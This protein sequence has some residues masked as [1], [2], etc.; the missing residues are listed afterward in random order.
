MFISWEKTQTVWQSP[1]PGLQWLEGLEYY[2]QGASLTAHSPDFSMRKSPGANGLWVHLGGENGPEGAGGKF[3]QSHPLFV[4]WFLELSLSFFFFLFKHR[5]HTRG[6]WQFSDVLVRIEGRSHWDSIFPSLCYE[7]K[8]VIQGA[9]SWVSLLSGRE[10]R[11]T[12][13]NVTWIRTQSLWAQTLPLN[14]R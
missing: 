4:L 12:S 3:I 8:E 10:T 7:T 9:R 14:T 2:S 6:P 1:G 13:H 5:M 11:E